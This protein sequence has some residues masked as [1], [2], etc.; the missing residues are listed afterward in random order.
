MAYEDLGLR[1][2]LIFQ[3]LLTPSLLLVQLL[4][5]IAGN[6]SEHFGDQR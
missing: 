4:R 6:A 3:N 2:L 1:K 5:G